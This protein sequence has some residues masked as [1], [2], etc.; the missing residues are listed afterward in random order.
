MSDVSNMKTELNWNLGITVFGFL[1]VFASGVWAFADASNKIGD[2]IDR[3]DKYETSAAARRAATDARFGKLEDKVQPFD[4]Y[5]YRTATVEAQVKAI[6][7]RL[8]R[9]FDVQRETM[10]AIRKDIGDVSLQVGLLAQR[11]DA[12]VPRQKATASGAMGLSR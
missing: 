8:D 9:G 1:S 3:M 7:D 10:D 5:Q 6:N 2:L 12:V 11:L 4:N